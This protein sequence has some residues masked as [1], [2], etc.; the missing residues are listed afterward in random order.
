VIPSSDGI[1]SRVYVM[2]IGLVSDDLLK[3]ELDKCSGP[4][5]DKESRPVVQILERPGRKEG[6]TNVPESLRKVIAE[7]ALLNGRGAA[8]QIADQFGVSSSSVSA[9]TKGAT[10]T[11]TYNSPNK[12]LI[13]HINKS[14]ERAVKKASKTLN[15]AL[16]AISQEKLDYADA[17]DLSSIAKDMSV[18][19]KNLEPQKEV[20]A[21]AGKNSPQFII[22]APQFKKEESFEVIQVQE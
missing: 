7:E 3:A 19:I 6:D 8:L 12:E 20:E 17:K 5:S 4:G 2:P 13:N 21:E 11:T 10:S 9:Y 16:S 14:R 22:Y 18:I 15:G 1:Y